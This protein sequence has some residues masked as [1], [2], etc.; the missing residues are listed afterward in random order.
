MFFFVAEVEKCE[1][2]SAIR[3]F[4]FGRT[5]ESY[6]LFSYTNEVDS[7]RAETSGFY[8]KMSHAILSLSNNEDAEV[9]FPKEDLVPIDNQKLTPILIDDVKCFLQLDSLDT[10]IF[11]FENGTDII[12]K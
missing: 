3:Q 12:F 8:F 10:F 9:Y 7:N 6:I 4:L 1:C 5:K 2:F 11:K